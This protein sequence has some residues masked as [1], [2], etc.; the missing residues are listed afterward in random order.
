MRRH[1]VSYADLSRRIYTAMGTNCAFEM[2]RDE[3]ASAGKS[4]RRHV[5]KCPLVNVRRALAFQFGGKLTRRA[6]FL[7]IDVGLQ[8]MAF[9]AR[10]AIESNSTATVRQTRFAG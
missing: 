4:E 8:P 9:I 6:G 5:E 1:P 10:N 3:C 7:P 2:T